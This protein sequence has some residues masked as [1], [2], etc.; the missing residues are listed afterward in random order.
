MGDQDCYG[1]CIRSATIL[2][3]DSYVVGEHVPGGNSPRTSPS[4]AAAAFAE[5]HASEIVPPKPAAPVAGPTHR[6]NV[7]YLKTLDQRTGL[8]TVLLLNRVPTA[9]DQQF[10]KSLLTPAS[11]LLL[12][13]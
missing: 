12:R 6:Y 11:I 8:V 4:P 5:V 9:I 3:Q 2:D 7:P 1:G 10:D 13:A